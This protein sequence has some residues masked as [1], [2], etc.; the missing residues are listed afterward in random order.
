MR[1]VT[2]ALKELTQARRGARDAALSMLPQVVGAF[3]GFA[4]SILLARGLGPAGMGAYALVISIS[5]VVQSL[6]DL[7]IGQTAVRFA[8][9]AANR[10]DKGAQHAVLRWALGWRLAT[11]TGVGAAAFLLAPVLADRLWHAPELTVWIRVS[12]LTAIFGAVAAVPTVYF[13]SMQQFGRNAAVQCAQT[14]IAFLGIL[15]V[16]WWQM[17]S[18]GVVIVVGVLAAAAGAALFLSF[19]PREVLWVYGGRSLGGKKA[20]DWRRHEEPEPE[21]QALDSTSVG[22]FARFMVISSIL[23]TLTLRADVWLMGIYLPKDQIGLY[24][25]AQR[26]TLP[27]LIVLGGLHTA[28]WPRVSGLVSRG[29]VVALIRRTSKATVAVATV[30]LPYAILA[31]LAAPYVFGREYEGVV[32]LGQVLCFRCLIAILGI[33]VGAIGYSVGL[34]RVYPLVNSLQLAVVVGLNLL[35]LPTRGPMGAAIAL[36]VNDTIGLAAIAG[37]TW[38]KL[39]TLGKSSNQEEVSTGDDGHRVA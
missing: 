39:R 36:L 6:S 12:L 17:W 4:T 15:L 20:L 32:A 18:V 13:Q 11:A 8:A 23:V 19:V 14:V 34:V 10:G 29:E 25:V 33:P 9:R 38:Y 2:G 30:L 35:L 26:F 24:T 1:Q 37:L 28:L 31:P 7:G 27:L 5:Q 22:S 3:T 21:D 16:A